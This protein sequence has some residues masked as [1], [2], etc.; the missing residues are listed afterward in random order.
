MKKAV[1][2][3]IKIL[4]LFC[5]SYLLNFNS[6]SQNSLFPKSNLELNENS[7]TVLN[8]DSTL[9][10]SIYSEFGQPN[11][12]KPYFTKYFSGQ[13]EYL[14]PYKGTRLVENMYKTQ[15]N[16]NFSYSFGIS[17][18]HNFKQL[19][20]FIFGNKS[21]FYLSLKNEVKFSELKYSFTYECN[22]NTSQPLVA[23][24]VPPFFYLRRFDFIN[25]NLNNI[26]LKVQILEY[27]P[28]IQINRMVNSNI[29]LN[30]NVGPQLILRT[31]D[32]RVIQRIGVLNFN[33]IN[34]EEP[35]F[36][37]GWQISTGLKFHKFRLGINYNRFKFTSPSPFPNNGSFET[38]IF[39]NYQFAEKDSYFEVLKLVTEYSF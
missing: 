38:E 20:K 25:N 4:I 17:L 23:P 12:F 2:L 16:G 39:G 32:Y 36:A 19:S 8:I 35:K 18:G 10:F 29:S 30:L 5:T 21:K 37:F 1:K 15:V 33:P 3:N 34:K 13:A 9:T 7:S 27:S 6:F 26:P 22:I 14:P 31:G 11:F 28:T 24:L